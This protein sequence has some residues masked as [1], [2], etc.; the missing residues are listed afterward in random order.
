MG[1][2]E[3]SRDLL[4]IG[5]LSGFDITTE[6]AVTKLMHLLG[7]KQSHKD[8]VYEL[9]T[10]ISGELTIQDYWNGKGNWDFAIATKFNFC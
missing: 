4:N 5:V 7:E 10:S 8:I 2:Y 3:T 1:Q 6:A 9:K